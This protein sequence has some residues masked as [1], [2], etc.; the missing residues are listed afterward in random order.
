MNCYKLIRPLIFLL[1]EEFSHD[2]ASSLIKNF[3]F[4]KRLKTEEILSQHVLNTLF[5]NP[6]GLAAG[7]DKNAELFDQLYKYNFGFIECGTV[8]PKSQNGNAKP[9]LFRLPKDRALI[10]RFGFNNVG[11][12]K[13][14]HNFNNNR[15]KLPSGYPLGINIGKNKNQEDFLS[16]YLSLIEKFYNEASYLTINISSPNTPNLRDIQNFAN[17]NNLMENV[18]S[19]KQA[20][21]NKF[22]KKTPI[23][24]K[25]APDQTEESLQDICIL[26]RK[27]KIDGLIISNTTITR[28]DYLRSKNKAESGGLSG[29]PLKTLANQI[30]ANI[31]KETDGKITLIGVGGI[32]SGDDAYYR[33]LNGASLIQ[34][35]S[36]LIYNGLGIVNKINKELSHLLKM[37][38]F[39]NI[40]E[41]I[42]AA[43]SK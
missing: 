39:T 40:K 13:F 16:D 11:M 41:A 36:S 28:P 38:G 26:S 18:D 10:N 24:Y 2:L 5:T 20:L 34:I 27:Y 33:I 32:E 6:V 31:Y 21:E 17:L 15:T 30:L 22:N 35:Y 37:N 14:A 9:R 3:T 23:L 12:Q 43:I 7:F 25:I 8:T 1:P 19:L 42:G 29:A 4:K